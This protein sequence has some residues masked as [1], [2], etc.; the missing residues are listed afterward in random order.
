MAGNAGG[1]RAGRAFVEVGTDNNPLI[2]GLKAGEKT[3]KSWGASVTSIGAQVG[4]VGVAI[5]TGFLGVAKAFADTGSNLNDM[6][7][8]TGL[9]VE[10][11]STL[12]H[13]ASM[14]GAELGDVEISTKK[15]QKA[16]A[17]AAGGSSEAIVAFGQIGLD[18]QKLLRL[19]PD[20][21]FESVAK[22]IG[23]IQNP[24]LRAGSAL[25]IFGKSGTSLLPLISEFDALTAEA[26]KFGLVWTGDEAKNADALGD[27]MDLVAATGKRVFNVIGG[28]V[29]PA[30]T[31]FATSLA[32]IGAK[33]SEFVKNNEGLVVS[34]FKFGLGAVVA[35]GAI[36][37]LGVALTATG[38]ALG[39]VAST[40]GTIGA[41][42]TAL[43]SPIG[44]VTA[45][46]AGGT[47]A[48]LNYS[49][50]GGDS[51][52][53]LGDS[54]GQLQ[55]DATTAF[56]GIA[57]AIKGGD[58]M[59]GAK[60]LWAGL[61]LEFLKGTQ[62]LNT[63]WS[64][65]GVAVI[66]VFRGVSFKISSLMIDAMADI[67][68]TFADSVQ[69]LKNQWAWVTGKQ[70]EM[71]NG[72]GQIEANRAGAQDALKSQQEA[73]QEARRAAAKL[74]LSTGEQEVMKATAELQALLNQAR[75]VA[76]GSGGVAKKPGQSPFDPAALDAGLSSA[77]RTAETKG[78]FSGFASARSLGTGDTVADAVKDQ[79]KEA[80]KQTEELSKVRRA[81]ENSG[82][83]T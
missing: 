65:W 22:A 28:A 11:L 45:A 80:K 67:Q 29:A 19:S 69:F 63:V 66:E 81:V 9:S 21:Q 50:A 54:F 59:L 3:L 12:G 34:V 51:L 2:K 75:S 20:Q 39:V 27:A 36:V 44:I 77:K 10:M 30:L 25:A 71:N 16:L 6:A 48:F 33:V 41:A 57:D 24:A 47:F 8:R 37:T 82:R 1:I 79:T 35:G 15:M 32:E 31:S 64:D 43:A 70:A 46:M 4:G 72:G 76:G 73:E 40:L 60:V 23:K 5:T 38:A 55:T 53:W 56:Q 26:K 42:F 68:K 49:K 7:T 61:R 18:F 17:S 52:A 58:I 14:T 13:A 62:F 78:T 74:S 83:L